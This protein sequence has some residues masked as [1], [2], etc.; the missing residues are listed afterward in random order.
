[1]IKC[2]LVVTQFLFFFAL[3]V[4]EGI[5]YE[6]ETLDRHVLHIVHIDPKQYHFEVLK[7]HNQVFGRETVASLAQ[8]KN[9]LAAINGGFF[10]MDA[11]LSGKPTGLLM[12]DRELVSYRSG[13]RSVVAFTKDKV[14]IGRV[15]VG[16]EVTF[17]DHKMQVSICNQ[18]PLEGEIALFTSSWAKSSLTPY[19]RK[20]LVINEHGQ[21]CHLATHG[22]NTIPHKGWV[23]S[24][25]AK[26]SLDRFQSGDRS[27]IHYKLASQTLDT[28]AIQH[29]VMGIPMLVEQGKICSDLELA[30][31][32][33]FVFSPH[34]RTAIGTKADGTCVIVVVEHEHAQKL[35]DLS[36]E[37]V[38]V[39]LR[40]NNYSPKASSILTLAEVQS[41]L[42][43]HF[44]EESTVIGL[45]L[46]ELAE[47]MRKLGCVQAINLDGGGTS[48]LYMNG[49]IINRTFGDSDEALGQKARAVSDAIIITK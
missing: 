3:N 22:D 10:E 43:K 26:T 7:A 2:L 47:I 33:S 20:E 1:M 46:P 41:L 12:I 13:P 11:A 19:D 6:R 42:E 30:G 48:T 31:S 32:S 36:L 15:E 8:R 5:N 25:P 28:E 4:A 45:C 18:F 17:K 29:M 49:R 44:S 14:L 24:F 37:Q 39:F 9:A 16:I 23:I 35:K 34:A 27:C 40:R 38:Q 21:I